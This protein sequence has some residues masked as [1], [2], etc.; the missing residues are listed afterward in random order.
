M[1]AL[2]ELRDDELADHQVAKWTR[3]LP[4]I[5]PVAES[6]VIELSPERIAENARERAAEPD[7]KADPIPA[8]RR[9]A[10]IARER[11]A[12][13]RSPLT[14]PALRPVELDRPSIGMGLSA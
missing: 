8:D 11:A 10:A 5:V 13:E 12:A 2:P 14:D 4:E 1:T 6:K 9:A 7:R 3:E